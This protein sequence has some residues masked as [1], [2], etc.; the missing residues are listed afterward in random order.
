MDSRRLFGTVL[1]TV[2]VLWT[3]AAAVL[4]QYAPAADGPLTGASDGWLPPFS[5]AA[6][7]PSQGAGRCEAGFGESCCCP[8]WT[9]SADYIILDR[10][11]S[12]NQTLVSTVSRSE[13]PSDPGT[14]VLNANDLQQ[15]FA[16]GPRVGLVRHGDNG[17]D[18]ELSYFQIDGWNDYRSFGPT[19]ADWLV[20]TAPGGFLQFQ[21]H[22]N[23]QMMVWD[24]GSRLYNAEL[25]LRW[26]PCARIT[27]LA[28]FRWVDLWEDLE[29]TLPPQRS[30]P[31]WDT[32]TRS[33]LY[34][35]QIGADGKLFQRGG[36][37]I[38]GVVKAG[39]FDNDAEETTGV[40]IYRTVYYESDSANCPAFLGELGLQCKYQVDR[41]LS[42]KLGYAAMWLQ[43]VA[44]A[45][46][47][48]RKP[49]VTLLSR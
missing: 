26:D 35:F 45:P 34:G 42:L 49:S 37:S 14:E 17:W 19:P 18:L 46:P 20:M 23:T 15:G 8:R 4:G 11:G 31:F 40:S 43:G 36:F 7:D 5:A 28:G 13:P 9:A 48:S 32:N 3:S 2:F 41:R 6:P 1:G 33:N 10:V 39:I 30:V 12:F 29:G 47:R 25:N 44:L 22:K 27:L 21:D 16:G 38:D 24:Y